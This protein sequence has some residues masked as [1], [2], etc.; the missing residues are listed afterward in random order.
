MLRTEG[1]DEALVAQILPHDNPSAACNLTALNLTQ[2]TV[3]IMRQYYKDDFQ[4]LGY[5]PTLAAAM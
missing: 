5:E 1:V 4:L 2:Q 3:D